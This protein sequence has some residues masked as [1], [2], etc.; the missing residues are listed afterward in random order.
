MKKEKLKLTPEK[1]KGSQENTISNYIP[2]KWTE[3]EMDKFLQRYNLPR[4]N[5]EYIENMNKL[6]TSTETETV[7]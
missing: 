6:I 5:Q 3:E 2:I 4:L 7:I 1:Y